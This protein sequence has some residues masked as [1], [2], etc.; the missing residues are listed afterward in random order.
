MV[1]S[2]VYLKP[3]SEPL[4]CVFQALSDSTRRRIIQRLSAE[5][6]PISEL[7]APFRMSLPAVSKHIRV[8]E[9]AGLITR[10]KEG[11]I[12]TVSLQPEPMTNAIAWLERYRRHWQNAFANLETFLQQEQAPK[13]TT[14][15]PKPRNKKK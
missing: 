14:P 7:A 11:R 10:R 8:L 5:P 9:T 6:M 12:S 2:S 13:P 1:K 3:T 15:T 4:D